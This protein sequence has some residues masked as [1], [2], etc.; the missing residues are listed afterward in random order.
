MLHLKQTSLNW[1]IEHALN[2]GDT[3]VFPL[4]FEFG[5]IKFDWTDISA[6]LLSEDILNWKTRPPRSLLS[7]KSRYGFRIIT[8]LDPLDFLVFAALVYEIGADLEKGRL[9][10]SKCVAFSNRFRPESD[11][12]MYSADVGYRAFQ[13]TAKDVATARVFSHVAVTDIADFYPRIYTHRLENALRSCTKKADHVT[14]ICRMLA[15]WN[16]SESHGIPVGSAPARLL[17]E[18][19][20]NDIDQQ[21]IAHGIKFI[22]FNDD[23][24]LFA[25]SHADAYRHLAVLAQILYE[26]HGLTL[27]PQKTSIYRSAA[28]VKKYLSGPADKELDALRSQFREFLDELGITDRY[29]QIEFDDLDEK[30]KKMISSLNLKDF[31][32][33][34][35]KKGPKLDTAIIKFILRRMAQLGD[36]S[37][38]P[39]IVSNI[40]LIHHAYA[41]VIRY[42]LKLRS[43]ILPRRHILGATLIKMLNKSM[44]S[45]LPYYRM[46]TFSMFTRSTEWN[47]A[48]QFQALMNVSRDQFSK[49]ELILAMGR[50]KHSHWFQSQWRH[51]FDEPPWTRRALLA[52]GSCMAGD[53]STHWYRSLSPKLDLLEKAVVKWAKANPFV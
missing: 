27:Q 36:A 32:I 12:R 40:E 21:L 11:G 44:F 46:W 1:A 14:A 19:T 18:I 22:R 8:Q 35:I 47:N 31:F 53:A 38:V 33:K 26:N 34:E 10:I 39:T 13:Q 3:D 28:F 15:G 41:D 20:I 17:A 6:S 23:F 4:P 48:Q 43:L 25:K 7:P 51:L 16:V 29:E 50:A 30:Q 49:R 24:R 2:F 52:A 42:F 5:A 37:L 45:E 9:P